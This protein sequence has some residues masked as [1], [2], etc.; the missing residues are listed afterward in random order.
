MSNER[1]RRD[2]PTVTATRRRAIFG[3]AVGSTATLS[4]C[5]EITST[6]LTDPTVER[7]DRSTTHTY[8]DEG[9]RL[10][11]I[12]VAAFPEPTVHQWRYP[13]R[14]LSWHADEYRLE[15]LRY[16][17]RPI[18][19]GVN[20]EFYLQRPS[21]FPWEPIQFSR[22]SDGRSTV[23][24]VPD[25]GSQGDGSVTFELILTVYEEEP[26]D[27]RVAYEQSLA[28]EGFLGRS[29]ELQDALELTLPGQAALER[30]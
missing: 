15:G 7:T 16:T 30:D 12:D 10:A 8:S 24:S 25:L 6:S 26:F 18:G 21:G 3:L 2:P 11:E 29:Y 27:L 22:S 5:T 23:L 4:G 17:F 28:P 9:D 14:L 1:T 19:H 13:I 20:V